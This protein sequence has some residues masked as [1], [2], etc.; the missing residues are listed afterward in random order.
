MES[1]AVLAALAVLAVLAALALLA[2]EMLAVR[3]V[4]VVMRAVVAVVAVGMRAYPLLRQRVE[5]DGAAALRATGE[6]EHR[7][8][9]AQR[10]AVAG[11]ERRGARHAVLRHGRDLRDAVRNLTPR[12]QRPQLRGS[13]RGGSRAKGGRA[14]RP[15]EPRAH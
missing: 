14:G 15:R 2:V 11:L 6:D 8:R 4:A 5:L 1:L 10:A 7:P 13:G 9:A 12:Q 3:A